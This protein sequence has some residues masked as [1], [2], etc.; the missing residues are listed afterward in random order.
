AEADERARQAELDRVRAEGERAKAEA[1]A[2]EQRKR[3]RVQAALGVA[4]LAS[5]TLIG[6]GLWWEERKEHNRLQEQANGRKEALDRLRD[7]LD[8]ADAALLTNR[9]A[10]ADAALERAKELLKE[11]ETSELRS[12]YDGLQADRA[13]VAELDRVWS[14]ANAIVDDRVPGTTRRAGGL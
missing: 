6:F 14:R 5:A 12:R 10:D 1:E 9:L 13:T 4:V 7:S 8:R 11:V 3:R 2:R